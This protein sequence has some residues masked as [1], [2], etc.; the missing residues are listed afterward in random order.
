[1][2]INE[3]MC[4]F[5]FASRELFNNH[6]TVSNPYQNDDAWLMQEMFSGVEETLFQNLVCEPLSLACQNYKY[7][8]PNIFVK[9]H[10]TDQ[11]GVMVNREID[12]GYWDFGVTKIR[13][14]TKMTFISFYDW[15][16]LCF[17]DNQYVEVLIVGCP[18][19]PEITG[20]H[21]LLE[22]RSVVFDLI[23]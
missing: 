3:L 14:D 6:F 8:Q 23:Y 20:K 15:E 1:M 4:K 22:A 19:Y 16:N 10:L 5:R 21:A 9:F 2:N 11:L 12:S 7:N 18:Q 17:R 13:S